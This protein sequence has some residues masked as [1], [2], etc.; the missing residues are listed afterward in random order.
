M[1]KSQNNW[2]QA[3]R[4]YTEKAAEN[5]KADTSL[6]VTGLTS[7]T[8]YYFRVRTQGDGSS[9]SAEYGDP[10]DVVEATTY[11]FT[12]SVKYQTQAVQGSHPEWGVL[13]HKYVQVSIAMTVD[14]DIPSGYK[15][16]LVLNTSETGFQIDSNGQCDWRFRL[17]N[18]AKMTDWFMVAGPDTSTQRL[19]KSFRLARCGLGDA[20]NS[21]FRV[22][23]S[24]S[25]GNEFLIINSGRIEQAWHRSSN[26]VTYFVQG[27]RVNNGKY[28]ING[29][30]SLDGSGTEVPGLFPASPLSPNPALLE[31]QNYMG[32]VKVWN[33]LLKGRLSLDPAA[34][35]TNAGIVIRGYWDTHPAN[36]KD[37]KC[38]ESIACTHGAGTYP[39]IGN[40]QPF[41]VEAP[42]RWGDSRKYDPNKSDSENRKNQ[43]KEKTWTDDWLKYTADRDNYQFLPKVLAHEFG[44]TIGLQHTDVSGN[45][46]SHG[47]SQVI[48]GSH[49]RHGAEAIYP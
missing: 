11:G 33:N 4:H 8:I 21:G 3:E 2:S 37:S 46:M 38:G 22:E 44:H 1:S 7:G 24:D 47:T 34:S 12:A 36:G 31:H 16:R 25:S 49:D 27:S 48:L 18:D 14:G 43:P 29:G 19:V 5:E 30:T 26:S 39:V 45:I 35:K 28:I 13:D 41:W 9:Y 23:G 10:S 20:G 6:T 40:G 32:A 42:P 17:P 15:F